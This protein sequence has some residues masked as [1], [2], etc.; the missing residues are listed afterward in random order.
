MI[1]SRAIP[2]IPDG[3]IQQ[4]E[5]LPECLPNGA[6]YS[7]IGEIADGVLLLHAKGIGRYRVYD[8][9]RIDFTVDT[10]ADPVS[11]ERFLWGNA[12]AGLLHQRGELPLHAASVV[13]PTGTHAI[14]LCGPSGS[15]K[16]TTAANLIQNAWRPLADDLTRISLGTNA[17]LAWPGNPILRL[18]TDA[19]EKLAVDTSRCAREREGKAKFAV[20]VEDAT[21]PAPLTAIITLGGEEA[22][23]RFER[24]HGSEALS[25][26]ASNVVGRRKLRALGR[27][28]SHFMLMQRL[29]SLCPLFRL[30]GRS[31]ADAKQLARFISERLEQNGDYGA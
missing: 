19:C 30:H 8:G 23:P 11:V 26:L 9:T 27:L 7:P 20:H 4:L 12:L 24:L 1:E 3:L 28:E 25:V 14:A 18:C 17:L 15:G 29:A 2:G 10:G 31:S 16:S 5:H 21:D 6:P 22:T 13:S